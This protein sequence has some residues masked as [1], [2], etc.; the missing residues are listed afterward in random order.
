MVKSL[1]VIAAVLA[2]TVSLSGKSWILNDTFVVAWY[3]E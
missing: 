3:P 2:V 1:L